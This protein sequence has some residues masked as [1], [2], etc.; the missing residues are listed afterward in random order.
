MRANERTDE[1]VAQYL[2][3]DSCLFQTTVQQWQR[4]MRQCRGGGGS[5]ACTPEE[6]RRK[7]SWISLSF[8]PPLWSR[9]NKTSDVLSHLLVY[10]LTYSLVLPC[11]L[12][13]RAPLRLLICSLILSLARGTV[14][15]SMDFFFCC[16]LFW[17][18]VPPFFRRDGMR[19]ISRM[20]TV[21]ESEIRRDR[22]GAAVPW[23]PGPSILYYRC[24]FYRYQR[25]H[26][27]SYVETIE[28]F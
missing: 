3:L 12:C 21:E 4:R 17:T 27:L 19:V 22:R 15:D 25:I 20:L 11:L 28:I 7:P 16:F 9:I 23:W 13:L 5:T 10:S 14:N 8:L 1:R 6:M 24:L 2:R 26:F 18:I